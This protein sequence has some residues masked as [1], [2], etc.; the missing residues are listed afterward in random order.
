M[1]TGRITM[2]LDIDTDRPGDAQEFI[3]YMKL[4]AQTYQISRKVGTDDFE[5]LLDAMIE[6]IYVER[7]HKNT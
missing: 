1:T 7:A 5:S 4:A 2:F 3:D 6:D